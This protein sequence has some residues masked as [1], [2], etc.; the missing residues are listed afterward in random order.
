LQ[1]YLGELL[2]PKQGIAVLGDL[3][4]I[5]SHFGK[6]NPEIPSHVEYCAA[7]MFI[8]LPPGM[9]VG[10][11]SSIRLINIVS[12]MC[13]VMECKA[14]ELDEKLEGTPHDLFI[15]VNSDVDGEITEIFVI[16]REAL[17]ERLENV[18]PLSVAMLAATFTMNAWERAGE[19]ARLGDAFMRPGMAAPHELLLNTL[20]ELVQLR[21]ERRLACFV[22]NVETVLEADKEVSD[23]SFLEFYVTGE[24]LKS[25]SK[26]RPLLDEQQTAFQESLQQNLNLQSVEYKQAN[27]HQILLSAF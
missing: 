7:T 1:R 23:S 4:R 15:E 2:S 18:Q 22:L 13:D 17:E 25:L 24:I 16:S 27:Y 11:E 9:A 10:A 5:A 21:D 20:D 12:R 8:L 3:K 6:T 14:T 19:I 26:I